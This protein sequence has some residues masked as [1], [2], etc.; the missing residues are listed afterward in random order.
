MPF[1]EL[2]AFIYWLGWK[3]EAYTV[4]NKRRSEARSVCM[5]VFHSITP[6][7]GRPHA[8]CS[9]AHCPEHS[10]IWINSCFQCIVGINIHL[11]SIGYWSS[12]VQ[13]WYNSD[14][15]KWWQPVAVASPP[16]RNNSAVCLCLAG[17]NKLPIAAF[18]FL[19]FLWQQDRSPRSQL[20]VV[21][22]LKKKSN[23]LRPSVEFQANHQ[24]SFLLTWK[25]WNGNV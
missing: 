7:R 1:F 5:P 14:D 11:H 17:I 15:Q 3:W 8:K 2:S 6:Y 4:I 19:G 23:S 22:V 12:L 21:M 25:L 24:R 18:D 16:W 20:I 13:I 10:L 9:V